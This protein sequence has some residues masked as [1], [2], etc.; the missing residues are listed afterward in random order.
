MCLYIEILN[1]T[2]NYCVVR[3]VI[4]LITPITIHTVCRPSSADTKEKK[5]NIPTINLLQM[6]PVISD[7]ENDISI[8]TEAVSYPGNI[9]AICF[10]SFVLFVFFHAYVNYCV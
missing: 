7:D 2:I 6:T 10:M 9:L 1:I 8:T 4:W 3:P 5:K